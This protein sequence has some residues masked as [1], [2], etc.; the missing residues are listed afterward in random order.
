MLGAVIGVRPSGRFGEMEIDAGLVTEFNEK[1]NVSAGLINGGFMVFNKKV[2]DKYFRPSEDLILEAE[3]LPK[4]VKNKQLGV[5]KHNGFW[6]CIDTVRE[7]N[8]LNEMW[9]NNNAPWKI[10]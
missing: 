3:V 10:W 2:I 7:Y 1:P 4:I 6:Q 5:Y 8:I 9:K